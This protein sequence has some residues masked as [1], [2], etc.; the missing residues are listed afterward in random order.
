MNYLSSQPCALARSFPGKR[1]RIIYVSQ[2]VEIFVNCLKHLK[3]Y[4]HKKPQM[5]N[6]LKLFRKFFDA[7]KECDQGICANL[8]PVHLSE[9][10][11]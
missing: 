11:S 3:T 2:C 5:N 1:R 6:S 9:F 4:A 8:Y 7:V 10:V